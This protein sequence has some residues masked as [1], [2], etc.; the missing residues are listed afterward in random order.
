MGGRASRP[1]LGVH[2][3]KRKKGGKKKTWAPSPNMKAVEMGCINNKVFFI[4]NLLLFLPSWGVKDHVEF[5]E[6]FV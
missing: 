5:G 2:Y 3:M 4:I 1:Y 6:G